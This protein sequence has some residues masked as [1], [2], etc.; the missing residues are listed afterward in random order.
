[1][2]KKTA[3]FVTLVLLTTAVS[4]WALQPPAP[5]ARPATP[6]F[7]ELGGLVVNRAA[8]ACVEPRPVTIGSNSMILTRAVL[9][10][11]TVLNGNEDYTE[12]WTEL[13]GVPL[14]EG[15]DLVNLLLEEP[16]CGG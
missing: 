6:A 16:T 8:I 11:G 10:N 5:A 9:R 13:L 12:V 7:I 14:P 2:N 3:T 4:A 15:N 1:M